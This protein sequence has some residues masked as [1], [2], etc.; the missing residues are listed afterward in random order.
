ME[1]S[2]VFIDLSDMYSSMEEYV[3]DPGTTTLEFDDGS[4]LYVGG[5]N[6]D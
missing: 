6:A 5:W 2:S 4:V 3:N 1:D